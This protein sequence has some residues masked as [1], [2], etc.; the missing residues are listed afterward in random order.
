MNQSSPEVQA[1]LD[2]Q[3]LALD[4]AEYYQRVLGDSPAFAPCH[5]D[6]DIVIVGTPENLYPDSATQAAAHD[7]AL[8]TLIERGKLQ[9]FTIVSQLNGPDQDH[10]TRITP[11]V[12]IA[13]RRRDPQPTE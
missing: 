7:L 10:I 11:G 2:V 8:R 13:I 12:V 1:T 6:T 5:Y 3:A 9:G 4:L